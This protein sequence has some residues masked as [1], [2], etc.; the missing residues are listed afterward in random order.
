MFNSNFDTNDIKSAVS[1]QDVAARYCDLHPKRGNRVPCPFHNGKDDNL[2]FYGNDDYRGDGNDH[3]Y[4]FVCHE[5]GDVIKF[6]QTIFGTDFLTACK[7]INNDFGLGLAIDRKLSNSEKKE[8]ERKRKKREQMI[9]FMNEAMAWKVFNRDK[10]EMLY[11]ACDTILTRFSPKQ[12][13]KITPLWVWATHNMG[14]AEFEY[15]KYK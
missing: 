5:T 6:V 12:T 2:S 9:N 15:M 7:T 13:G 3:Y 10:A 4:C 11:F 8:M 14:S 1:V